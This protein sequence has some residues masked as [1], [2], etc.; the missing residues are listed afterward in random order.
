[1]CARGV[2][3]AVVPAMLALATIVLLDSARAGGLGSEDEARK[4]VEAAIAAC[5][6][7]SSA[8]RNSGVTAQMRHGTVVTGTCLEGVLQ[9]EMRG[10]LTAS[11]YEELDLPSKLAVLRNSYGSIYWQLYNGSRPG[12]GWRGTMYQVFHVAAYAKLLE[13]LIREVA[14]ERDGAA[15]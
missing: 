4:R 7:L 10:L 6:S 2:I 11:S 5:W 12:E 14:A 1:M 15:R 8:D 9:D 3:S 13:D